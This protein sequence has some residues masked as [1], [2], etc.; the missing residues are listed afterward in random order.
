MKKED[1]LGRKDFIDMLEMVISTKVNNQEGLSIAIDGK[2][3]CGKSFIVRE[4]EARLNGLGYLVVHYNCWQN[5]YYEEPLIA[6]LSVLV[7]A[8]NNLKTP[9]TI[10]DKKT[11]KTKK[12]AVTL[13]KSL[14]FSLLKNKLGV[15]LGEVKEA[16]GTALSEDRADLFCK[17]FD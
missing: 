15:D 5:D 2:W 3:G 14:L 13:L 6:I 1:L 12:I 11:Q 9:K 17:D 16:L 8:L 4:L 7:D 10:R